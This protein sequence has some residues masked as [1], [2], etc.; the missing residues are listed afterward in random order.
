MIPLPHADTL[1][2]ETWYCMYRNSTKPRLGHVLN[3]AAPSLLSHC[4]LLN[5][6]VIW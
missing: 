2:P 4:P 1:P 3:E 5:T 6:I